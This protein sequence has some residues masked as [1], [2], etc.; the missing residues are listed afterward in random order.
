MHRRQRHGNIVQRAI[1]LASSCCVFALL[2]GNTTPGVAQTTAAATK[3]PSSTAPKEPPI[4]HTVTIDLQRVLAE[5]QPFQERLREL[6]SKDVERRTRIK[7]LQR[8]IRKIE[9]LQTQFPRE[10][11]EHAEHSRRLFAAQAALAAAQQEAD[12]LLN[13]GE[14]R[15]YVAFFHLVEKEIDSYATQQNIGVV[16][17]RTPPRSTQQ[18]PRRPKHSLKA[19]CLTSAISTS[20]TQFSSN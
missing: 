1:E 14:T 3:A 4:R 19:L 15:L 12:Y 6:R 11:R 8:D 17:N 7:G 20:P 13:R 9:Q 18:M 5:Y 16:L 10:R 2:L